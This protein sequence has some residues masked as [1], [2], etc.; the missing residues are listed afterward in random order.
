MFESTRK[1]IPAI[2]ASSRPYG[3]CE[4]A[5]G[6][7]RQ[8]A[9]CYETRFTGPADQGHLLKI[10]ANGYNLAISRPIADVDEVA[11]FDFELVP[12][13][14]SRKQSACNRAGR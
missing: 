4:S 2:P 7:K 11:E 6:S 14:S 5:R 10:E 9:G 13:I 3:P 12:A 8:T 1:R